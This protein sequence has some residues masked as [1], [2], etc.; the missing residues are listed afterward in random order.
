MK[1]GNRE[2]LDETE[3]SERIHHRIRQFGTYKAY[4]DFL[5][6]AA[7]TV[8]RSLSGEMGV[9]ASILKDVGVTR[10]TFYRVDREPVPYEKEMEA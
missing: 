7:S 8:N 3:L 6:I 10:L 2:L 4:A 5:G 1:E 9:H